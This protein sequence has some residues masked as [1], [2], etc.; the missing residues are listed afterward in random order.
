M[1]QAK[2]IAGSIRLTSRRLPN[3]PLENIQQHYEK[4]DHPNPG[5]R[6][7]CLPVDLLHHRGE[8]TG[9]KHDH[10]HSRNDGRSP[11]I[12]DSTNDDDPIRRLLT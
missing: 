4:T 6:R 5:S 11:D 9:D 2:K 7:I 3:R 10:D 1:K 12:D 8:G